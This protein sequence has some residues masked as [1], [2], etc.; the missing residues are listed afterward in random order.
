[1]IYMP[2]RKIIPQL[3]QV[4][5]MASTIISALCLYAMA[6]TIINELCLHWS[7]Q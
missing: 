1:M 2:F 5:F 7:R 6:S 4:T 3:R